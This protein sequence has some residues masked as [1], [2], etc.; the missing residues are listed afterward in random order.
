M[1]ACAGKVLCGS[2]F[3]VQK[4]LAV[5]RRRNSQNSR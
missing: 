4:R 3:G 2:A 5:A 1:T